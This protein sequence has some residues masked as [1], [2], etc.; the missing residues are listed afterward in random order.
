MKFVT[1]FQDAFDNNFKFKNY[2]CKVFGGEFF[3][4][5]QSNTS[6]SNIFPISK[7]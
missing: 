2:F 3:G 7:E 6:S 4:S 5:V 1:W